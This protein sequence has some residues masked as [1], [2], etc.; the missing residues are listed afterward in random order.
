MLSETGSD[1]SPKASLGQARDHSSPKVLPEKGPTYSMPLA[2]GAE[3]GSLKKHRPV[4]PKSRPQRHRSQNKRLKKN[5]HLL[6]KESRSR[7]R[8]ASSKERERRPGA[9]PEEI[10]ES[11]S[12]DSEGRPRRDLGSRLDGLIP[13]HE[14]WLMEKLSLPIP[15]L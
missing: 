11:S 9:E 15:H 13:N 12:P 10:Q 3:E 5:H 7:S 6:K 8:R 14:T 4:S 1:S 2:Q